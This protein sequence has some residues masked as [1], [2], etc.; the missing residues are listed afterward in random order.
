M[1]QQPIATYTLIGLIN[2]EAIKTSIRAR[3]LKSQ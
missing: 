1:K 3:M 2:V